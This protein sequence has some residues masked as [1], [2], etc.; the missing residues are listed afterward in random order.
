M[1]RN[2]IIK[3]S[4]FCAS[5]FMINGC[6]YYKAMDIQKQ[7]QAIIVANLDQESNVTKVQEIEK[8]KL[9]KDIVS[10]ESDVSTLDKEI[11]TIKAK[12]KKAK[13]NN[14]KK[15]QKAYNKRLK[16]LMNKKL[17]LKK[18]ISKKKAIIEIL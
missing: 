1:N 14:M 6:A 4:V 11:S 7:R 18:D 10:F 5:L 17:A 2:S 15:A 8:L 3:L 13:Y 9:E 16:V 12:T